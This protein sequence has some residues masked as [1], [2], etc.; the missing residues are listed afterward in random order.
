[1]TAWTGYRTRR[2]AVVA[3]VGLVVGLIVALAAP[4]WAAGPTSGGPSSYTLT[5]S[6]TTGAGATIVTTVQ[7]FLAVGLVVSSDDTNLAAPTAVVSL[8]QVNPGARRLSWNLKVNGQVL[9]AG[10]YIVALEIFT[11]DGHPSGRAFP[12]P[13]V[14]T[15]GTDGHTSVVMSGALTAKT[16]VLV[17]VIGI[18]M[19][20]AVGVAGGFVLGR[21]LSKSSP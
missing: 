12:P 6:G 3:A 18:I 10:R 5:V 1:M 13:A 19:A 4:A 14:L 9:G 15:I 7:S 17:T 8:G 2:K 20:L 21:K 16:N 11:A